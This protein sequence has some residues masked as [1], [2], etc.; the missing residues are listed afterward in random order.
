MIAQTGPTT[1][2][3]AI[4]IRPKQFF[5]TTQNAGAFATIS[6]AVVSGNRVSLIKYAQCG[7]LNQRRKVRFRRGDNFRGA[8]GIRQRAGRQILGIGLSRF[9]RILLFRNVDLVGNR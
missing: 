7:L 2:F 4:A 8:G 1:D 3:Q 6:V 9:D 5:F